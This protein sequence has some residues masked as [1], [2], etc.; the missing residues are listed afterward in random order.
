[1]IEFV[2]S[3]YGYWYNVYVDEYYPHAGTDHLWETLLNRK[4]RFFNGIYDC[5]FS[6]MG[7]GVRV[8][9]LLGCCPGIFVLVQLLG[10]A[11]GLVRDEYV[12]GPH[13]TD[14]AVR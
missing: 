12:C 7:V 5:I 14:G 13:K 2:Y 1:M 3:G 4:D 6:E 9:I 11:G 10:P 8:V